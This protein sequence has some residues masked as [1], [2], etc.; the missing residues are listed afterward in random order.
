[1]S[2]LQD[3]IRIRYEYPMEGYL[4]VDN[5]PQVRL[6]LRDEVG[7]GRGVCGGGGGAGACG[8]VWGDG[9]SQQYITLQHMAI[10]MVSYQ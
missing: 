7:D 1:M 2:N 5:E 9:G 6:Q 8:G 10:T 3:L 4:M